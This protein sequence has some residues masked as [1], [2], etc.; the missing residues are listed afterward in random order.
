MSDLESKLSEYDAFVLRVCYS[1]DPPQCRFWL[2]DIE[3]QQTWHFK[4]VGE[5]VQFLEQHSADKLL[6]G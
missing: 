6:Q 1:N 2:K 4:D 3:G 5:L